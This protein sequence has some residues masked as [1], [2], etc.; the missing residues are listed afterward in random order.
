M[1]IIPRVKGLG[2]GVGPIVCKKSCLCW[3]KCCIRAGTHKSLNSTVDTK[4]PA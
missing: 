4:H 2:L 1:Q 3:A